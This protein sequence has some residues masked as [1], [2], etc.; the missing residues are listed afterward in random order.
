MN[1]VQNRGIYYPQD[2]CPGADGRVVHGMAAVLLYG[3]APA[4]PALALIFPRWHS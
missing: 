4:F 1:A 3:P 2:E